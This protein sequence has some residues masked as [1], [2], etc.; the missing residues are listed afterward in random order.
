MALLL[1]LVFGRSEA[2]GAQQYQGLCAVVKMEIIQELALERIGFL[3]TLEITNN[4]STASITDFSSTLSFENPAL[5]TV[6]KVDDSSQL[7][8]VQPPE[9]AGINSIDGTGIIRPGQTAV[10]KWFIIP[11]ISAGGESPTGIRYRIGAK[12]AGAI[13]GNPIPPE[14]LMVYPDTIRVKPE[15]QL[16]I[17]YF[18][19]RDV[20]GDDPFT[21]DTVESPIPFT[22]GVMVKNS[23]FGMAT[24]VRVV[25]QQPKIVENK[26]GLLL[27]AQLIGARVDDN[28]T[29]DSSLTVDL[30]NIEP[31]RCRKGAWDMITSLSGEFIDFKASYTHSSELGGRDTSVIKSLN[32]YFIVREALN[33]QPGRDK[34]LDFLA[35]TQGDPEHIPDTLYESDCNTVPVNRLS[36]VSVADY[37]GLTATVN[38]KA[39][40]ENWVYIRLDDPAQAKYPIASVVRS[41]GKVLNPRNYWT[42]LRYRKP[43]NAKLTYLNIFDFVSLGDYTYTVT[44]QPPPV[45]TSPPVTTVRF[46]GQ[47]AQADGKYYVTDQTQLYFTA[48]DASP[49]STWYKL[50]GIGS[51]Q[52]A[53]PFNIETPGEHTLE[54]YSRDSAGNQELTQSVTVAVSDSYPSVSNVGSDTSTLYIS[55]DAVSVRPTAATFWFDG[56]S[57]VAG[58]SATADIYQGAYAWPVIGQVPGSPTAN[59]GASLTVSGENVDY[60]RY[61]TG[62]GWSAENAVAAPLVLSGLSGTVNLK[63]QGRNRWGSYPQDTD[64]LAVTWEIGPELGPSLDGPETPSRSNDAVLSVSGS[65]YYCYRLDGTYYQPNLLPAEPVSLTRLAEGD[66]F[67][68]VL[69]RSGSGD[70]CPGDEPGTKASWRVEHNYGTNPPTAELVRHENLGPVVSGRI[71]FTWDGRSDAGAVVPP[72]WYTVV[73]TLN[74]SLGRATSQVRL[75]E[76]GNLLSDGSQVSD[77]GGAGQTALSA[78]GKWAVWQDQRDGV[79]NIWAKDISSAAD[80]S[81]AVSISSQN[82]ERPNTDGRYVVWEERQTD[83]TRDIWAMELGVANPAFAVTATPG[84]EEQKPVVEWP[85]IVYQRKP[86][87]NPS[88]PWQLAAKNL[89]TMQTSDVDPSTQDQLDVAIDG[90]RVVWQ[91]FRDQGWGEIYFKNLRTGEVRRLTSSI[92]GQ[93]HPDIYGQ[94]VVWSDNR[95]TQM[96][97]YGYNLLRDSEVRLTNSP[98][99]E[100]NPFINGQW[101]AFQEDLT[102]PLSVNLRMLHLS[103]LATV[104]L[105][106]EGSQKENPRLASGK[107]LWVESGSG[108]GQVMIGSIPDFQPVFNNKNTIT[109][110]EG[111]A[112]SQVDAFTLLRLWNGSAGVTGI[113]RYTSLIPNPVAETATW[114][115][116][117][118]TGDNF[119]LVAGNFL[120]AKFSGTTILDLGVSACGAMDLG[121][122]VNAVGY[123]CWPDRYSA[124]KLLRELGLANVSAIRLLD[125]QTGNW[126]AATVVDG[127]V[128]GDDFDISPVSVLM[129]EMNTPVTSWK[130]GG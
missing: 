42:N 47:M 113:T 100:D 83:G 115:G 58:L 64:F 81:A 4:E 41:D 63:V 112:S 2:F 39:D 91:D 5:T 87:S 8:F 102:G 56:L 128:A 108:Q 66:H 7:F 48:V 85:W 90:E 12:L 89:V 21:P 26:L 70:P 57:T 51:F 45:D 11:K 52:P 9:L 130:P 22:L 97:L 120:W 88:A 67:V 31:G 121:A 1:L 82:Q 50:D 119:P 60:Y 54:F 6:D 129:I 19:P 23:G 71:E 10:I 3:A 44:Y 96:D 126:K 86:V 124:Y 72:G 65:D 84:Y 34:L 75:V 99:D 114:S 103:S 95:N 69:A 59:T 122:G 76:V 74:D 105:T 25:S 78:A 94:W 53:Y 118:P 17:T 30:G 68:E 80:I 109:V 40:F 37:S 15:P 123:A 35:D 46:S 98:E 101:V 33:D 49:V 104:Q 92:Y 107:I 27:V 61:D 29:Q 111:M 93:Y 13:F 24:G 127:E 36:T 125:S 32:A 55:G 73:L 62:G 116:T 117:A 18:Q 16:D 106:N 77:A 28:P 43:D 14:M 110:T 20:D 79:W 38:A